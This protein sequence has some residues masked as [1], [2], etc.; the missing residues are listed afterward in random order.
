MFVALVITE[1]DLAF[2]PIS[3]RNAVK[4]AE[5]FEN[6]RKG[7]KVKDATDNR[8]TFS[9][10]T[11]QETFKELTRIERQQLKCTF[12]KKT[13]HQL[14]GCSKF[15]LEILVTRMMFVKENRLCFGCLK[16]GHV[17]KDCQRRL[18]CFTCNKK[19]LTCLHKDK[20][21]QVM[22]EQRKVC[23]STYVSESN[24]YALP[25]VS[26]TNTSMIVPVWLSTSS[27]PDKEVLVYAMLDNQSAAT[28]VLDEGCS[29]LSAEAEPTKLQVS[30]ISTLEELLNKQKI[31]DLQV[32]GY[33]THVKIPITIP[34][35][36]TK[37]PTD[38]SDIPTKS[39]AKKWNHLCPIENKMQ[40]LLDCN[41][42]F[43]IGCLLSSTDAKRSYRWQINRGIWKQ[44]RS[45]LEHCGYY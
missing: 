39:P 2:H 14:D 25:E 10:K 28:F 36:R 44:N 35:T 43:L 19:H 8:T 16:K 38:E 4:E 27:R 26:H 11:N 13:D 20:S 30:T 7:Q 22:K 23:D 33:S 31:K 29:D 18:T 42:G 41:V 17:S 3:Y 9:V 15:K 40:D 1:A 32:Q 5:M 37:I 12:C 34:F 24:S 21:I 6:V 45:R